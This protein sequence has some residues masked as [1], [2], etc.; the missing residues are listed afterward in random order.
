MAEKKSMAF[1]SR[2]R[3]REV[4][5][6]VPPDKSVGAWPSVQEKT[7]G[8]KNVGKSLRGGTNDDHQGVNEQEKCCNHHDT[9]QQ[10]DIPDKV[11]FCTIKKFPRWWQQS[12]EWSA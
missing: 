9:S 6:A 8:E 3:G 4:P 1:F 5:K 2:D 7:T 10:E 12:K 11:S